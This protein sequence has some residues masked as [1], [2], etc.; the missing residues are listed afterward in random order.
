MDFL[1]R[2]LKIQN[3]IKEII[4]MLS[5]FDGILYKHKSFQL[6]KVPKMLY[7]TLF[8]PKINYIIETWVGASEY[9]LDRV[10]ILRS[11]VFKTVLI[12]PI[13]TM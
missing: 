3:H 5:R 9:V 8:H 10:I 2:K 12:F 1:R 6:Q 4:I 13:M 11:E 7:Y